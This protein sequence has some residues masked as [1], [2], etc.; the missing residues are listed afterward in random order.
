MR[1]TNAINESYRELNTLI[2][3]IDLYGLAAG[4]NFREQ[5]VPQAIRALAEVVNLSNAIGLEARKILQ[6]LRSDDE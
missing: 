3:D 5:R 6:A 1:R 2:G 4:A